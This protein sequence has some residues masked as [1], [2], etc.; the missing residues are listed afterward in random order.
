MSAVINS[1]N[2][3]NIENIVLTVPKINPTTKSLSAA[4]INN[5]T[6][7]GLYIETPYAI[8]PFG[9]GAYDPNGNLEESKKNYTISLKEVA[10]PGEDQASVTHFFNIL[11]DLDEKIIDW[12]VEHSQLI[13]KKTYTPAQKGIVEALY[14]RCVKKSTPGKDGTV[15]P[16]RIDLKI[17]KKEDGS[18]DVNVFKDSPTPV[19]LP[20]FASFDGL[21][22]K[23]SSIKTIVQARIY[24]MP[25]SFGMNLKVIQIKIPTGVQKVGKPITYAFSEPIVAATSS[26]A[27]AS[28]GA[29][30]DSAYDSEV[31][32][33]E[34][35]V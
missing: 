17:M 20:S 1:K 16:D 18:P 8:T 29:T 14:K 28:A 9:V 11:R 15:Y 35:D 13:F 26:S 23:G 30:D 7:S 10:G 34:Q 25:G 5:D 27:S 33:G 19:E 22:N 4:I 21:V 12:G 2:I 32:V 24:F 3:E 31:D 6:K